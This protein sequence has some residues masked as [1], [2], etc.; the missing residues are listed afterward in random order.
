[1]M[2]AVGYEWLGDAWSHDQGELIREAV[3]SRGWEL[4]KLESDDDETSRRG[5]RKALAAIREGRA[6]ALVAAELQ[7]LGRTS[8]AVLALVASV[9]E[10]R[11]RLIVCD[12]GLDTS[13]ISSASFNAFV[14][15]LS[16]L[17]V[18]NGSR[19]LKKR[20]GR[21]S[22]IAFATREHILTLY[23]AEDWSLGRIAR[24]LQTRRVPTPHGGR[25]WYSSTVKYVVDDALATG[26]R[27]RGM[28][29]RGPSAAV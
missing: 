10:N 24:R 12:V 6:D 21:P 5:R 22:G 2:R 4:L 23:F 25:Q 1:M 17:D 27:P 29:R 8:R 3:A 26:K 13:R 28:R 9:V 16:L 7:A 18:G 19:S 15:R 14:E 11:G 20:S